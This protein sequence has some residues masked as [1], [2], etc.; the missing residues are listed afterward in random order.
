MKDKY[1]LESPDGNVMQRIETFSI[2]RPEIL[3]ITIAFITTETHP[4][5][6]VS[7]RITIFNL[8]F[9]IAFGKHE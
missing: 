8:Y 2:G 4:S 9:E 3:K 1:I 7:L 5:A 6:R